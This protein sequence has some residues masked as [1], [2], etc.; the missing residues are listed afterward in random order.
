MKKPTH[1]ALSTL[2]K[3]VPLTNSVGFIPLKKY[4]AFMKL[5]RVLAV[6]ILAALGTSQFQA[7]AFDPNATRAEQVAQIRA[8][9]DPQ[10]DAAYANFMKLKAKLSLEPSAL[11]SFN[12]VIE[13]FNETRA[14]INR[15]LSDASSVMKT[16][17]EYIQ[18]ELG[19]F[20]TSQFKLT[21]LASKIKTITCV[22]GK[23][24]KM[25]G[26]LTTP[27]CPKG[28]TKK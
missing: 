17:E 27:K 21:Q 7:Q 2:S 25:V 23:T 16:V 4:S 20:S 5:R 3:G 24:T 13:D 26:S 22:K 6:L 19:E 9:Y 1:V 28:Y 15:N 18:E 11:K 8:T 10:L 14:T 12:A